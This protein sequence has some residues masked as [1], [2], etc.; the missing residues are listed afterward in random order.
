MHFL[1]TETE[2]YVGFFSARIS[3]FETESERTV[4]LS[5]TRQYVLISLYRNT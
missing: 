4:V 1:K 5:E 2:R 3:S